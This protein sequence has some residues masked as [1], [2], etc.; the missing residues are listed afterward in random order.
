MTSTRVSSVTI[1]ARRWWIPWTKLWTTRWTHGRHS[2]VSLLAS[3]CACVR[4]V[5]SNY[6]QG[7]VIIWLEFSTILFYNFVF[8]HV[9]LLLRYADYITRASKSA[10]FWECHFWSSAFIL[11]WTDKRIFSFSCRESLAI[12]RF[13]ARPGH[14][15]LASWTSNVFRS[16]LAFQPDYHYRYVQVFDSNL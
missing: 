8:P 14:G 7:E 5:Q 12:S 11:N 4:F 9:G 13:L 16:S 2:S 10:L 1:R 6:H 3:P 15:W